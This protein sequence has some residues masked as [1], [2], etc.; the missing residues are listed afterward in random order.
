[1]TQTARFSGILAIFGICVATLLLGFAFLVLVIQ[2]GW[3]NPK[4]FTP[5]EA[6]L[7]GPI[8]TEV[9]PLPVFVA[10]PELF[11]EYFQPN[12]KAAGEWYEQFGMN[13]VLSNEASLPTGFYISN[14]RPK[15]GAPSPV[16]FVGISCVMCHSTVI[17]PPSMPPEFVV[18]SGNMDLNLFAWLDSFQT[19]ILDERL[20][21]DKVCN[22]YKQKTGGSVSVLQKG[23][24]ELWLRNARTATAAGAV[25]FGDPYSGHDV[26][27]SENVPTGPSRTQPFRT[28]VRRLMDRPGTDMAVYTKISPVFGQKHRKWAQVDGSIS[29]LNVRS[30]VAA[31]AAGATVQ[32][33]AIPDIAENIRQ[34]SDYTKS[35]NTA[36]FAER[37]PAYYTEE[38]KG[39]MELGRQVYEKH[40][41]DCHGSP[42]REGWVTGPKTG[43]IVRFES[44]GTDKE[45]VTFRRFMELPNLIHKAF[46][47]NHPFAFDR[48]TIR[49]VSQDDPRG[50]INAPIEH[51][52]A[53]APYLHNS[54]ILTLSELINLTQRREIFYRGLNEFD[55][56]N[57]GLLDL[58]ETQDGRVN[59]KFDT[60]KRGNS[61]KGHDYPWS[62]EDKERDPIKL[63]ALL[64]YLKSF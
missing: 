60:S 25:K 62:Y 16:E 64:S 30:S 49:P 5:R 1:M 12:G 48:S 2:K 29:D 44:I 47:A 28:L 53:R 13:N 10:L 55:L 52:Y 41:H 43:E 7:H 46:P 14:K 36:T 26:F 32:N 31:Y 57:I 20:T 42:S 37:F 40:C 8:G 22:V 3:D 58:E 18:G 38:D 56:K 9:M 21:I 51:V 59:F 45:R 34:A 35:L 6:F 63:R 61:N 54:S 23:M 4:S 24:M 11:P 33:M 27:D 39:Q 17:R 19:A 50:Y 15:S